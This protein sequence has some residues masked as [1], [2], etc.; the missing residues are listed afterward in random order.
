MLT[1]SQ[2]GETEP[3]DSTKSAD[4]GQLG[5]APQD[6]AIIPYASYTYDY[7]YNADG[8]LQSGG[9]GM[10]LLDVGFEAD[11]EKLFGWRGASFVMTAFAGHGSDFSANYAGDFGVASN[12]YHGNDFNLY[13]I[14]L[15]QSFGDGKS[16]FKIGQIAADDEFMGAD[17]AGNLINSVFGPFNTQSGNM[18]APIFPFAAP[19]AVIHYAPVDDWYVTVGIYAGLLENGDPD[20]RGFDWRWGGGAGQTIF[21][22]TGYVYND[23]G[24]IFKL[25]GYYHTGE[26][27]VFSTGEAVDGLGAIYGIVNHP[28][29]DGGEEGTS[30]STFLRGSL[31]T[32]E[33]RAVATG[34]IDTGVNVTN[35][36]KPGDALAFGVSHTLFGDDYLDATPGVTD[37][38]TVIE[39]TYQFPLNDHF[40]LQP[41]IQYILD[42]HESGRDTFLLGF[43]AILEF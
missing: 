42:P 39:A 15:Q 35:V 33:D 32:E 25:G 20:N 16:Y 27:E 41:N 14:Y 11:L 12:I 28:I 36:I 5:E 23:A 18:G 10:G 40:K 17:A 26:F 8:G 29:I 19:G 37:T 4:H 3:W 43:R 34:Y 30:V 1:S 22:E 38:E 9:A 13:N 31:V 24:G 7:I 21:A 2:S 6:R